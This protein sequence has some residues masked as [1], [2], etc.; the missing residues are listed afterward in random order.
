MGVGQALSVYL[1]R[2]PRTDSR[3]V[4]L[5]SRAPLQPMIQTGIAHVLARA[6]KRAGLARLSPHQL[7]HSLATEML[8]RGA[9]LVQI[10]QVLRHRSVTTTALL[11][12]RS[13]A[14]R[15]ASSRGRGRRCD[16]RLLRVA[17]D[18]NLELRR[19]LGFKL[20]HLNWR[21]LDF[22]R[23]LE[24]HRA[25]LISVR[26]ALDWAR[27]PADAHSSWWAR[28]LSAVRV[29]ARHLHAEDPRHQIPPVDLMPSQVRRL[30]PVLF[31]A[32]QITALLHATRRLKS[33][34]RAATHE[35]LFGLLAATG[36]RIGEAIRLDRDDLDGQQQLLVVRH[37]KFDKSR[38]VVLHPSTMAAL[39]R[40]ARVRDHYCP[41]PR[42]AALLV[43]LNGTRLQHC[44][45]CRTRHKRQRCPMVVSA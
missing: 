33:P 23:Y 20:H 29:L 30:V 35:T 31:T 39:R 36:M 37:S 19:A 18:R 24:A 11:R 27:Q 40:Y 41:R 42:S 17:V 3:A 16:M 26:H 15:C 4:F 12:Q 6:A 45:L 8:R 5:R 28:R 43:S 34:L 44:G 10:A 14:P 21:L 25:E 9:T 38:G 13:I 32:S 22:L 7:R 1:T 2:R